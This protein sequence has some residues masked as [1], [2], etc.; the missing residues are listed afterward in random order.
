[1]IERENK[2]HHDVVLPL[3]KALEEMHADDMRK[4]K[5]KEELS[6]NS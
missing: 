2:F 3:V 1:M 4:I 6:K 5:C